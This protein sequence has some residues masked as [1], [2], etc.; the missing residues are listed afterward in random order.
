M[1][2][3][4]SGCTLMMTLA[5][6]LTPAAQA[7]TDC[8]PGFQQVASNNSIVMLGERPEARL[9]SLSSANLV[10]MLISKNA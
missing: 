8:T 5:F 1:K 7:A 2:I 4:F 10:R 9:N 6:L 3:P